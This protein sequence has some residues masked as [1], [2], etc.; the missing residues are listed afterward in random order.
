MPKLI[1]LAFVAVLLVSSAGPGRE[2]FAK[3]KPIEAYEVPPGILAMQRYAA[4]G[5]VCEIG[6]EK[7]HYSPDVIRVDYELDRKELNQAFDELVPPD[8][9][10]PKS[11]DPLSN[12]IDIDGIGMTT[13]VDFENVSMEIYAKVLDSHK[14]GRLTVNEVA[15]AIKWKNR[16]CQ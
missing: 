5:Q 10:G 8:E 3:Y 16:K 4:D 6:L 9:R 1:G 12:L 2:R 11:T 14:H 15:A 13:S 7:L